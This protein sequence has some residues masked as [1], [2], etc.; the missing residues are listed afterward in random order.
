MYSSRVT[1]LSSAAHGCP[2][3][4]ARR[5]HVPAAGSA[6]AP[7]GD[8]RGGDLGPAARPGAAIGPRRGRAQHR[9]RR[10][11]CSGRAR[12][13]RPRGRPA[14][15]R[16]GRHLLPGLTDEGHRGHGGHAL[17]GRGPLGPACAPGP[18]PARL[19][20]LRTRGGHGVAHP[21]AHVGPAD[22]SL[23]ELRRRPPLLC[24]AAG[25]LPRAASRAGRRAAATSTTR[26]SGCSSPRRWP[27]SPGC[28]SRVR[29][30]PA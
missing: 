26:P 6:V 30:A 25:R 16:H 12:H 8:R 19:R 17:R 10:R 3:P 27:R 20:G 7:W 15:R 28:P 22:L 18:L 23:D 9:L 29:C 5:G 21:D 2:P 24:L 14:Q 4:H 13:P 11:R 1:L